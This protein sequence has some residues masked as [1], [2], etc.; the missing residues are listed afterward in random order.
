MVKFYGSKTT[1]VEFANVLLHSSD[2]DW[3]SITII[4]RGSSE[5]FSV[6]I[7]IDTSSDDT[8]RTLGEIYL[9]ML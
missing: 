7:A 5:E 4:R 8:V 9:R 1:A 6:H 3:Q 2:I